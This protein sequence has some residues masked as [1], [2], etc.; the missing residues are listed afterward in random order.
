MGKY[1]WNIEKA[2][3]FYKQ[4]GLKLITTT[5]INNVTPMLAKNKDGYIGYAALNMVQAN[6]DFR[7]FKPSYRKEILRYNVD[8]AMKIYGIKD[9]DIEDIY[10]KNNRVWV[11]YKCTCRNIYD[12]M[13][14]KFLGKPMCPKCSYNNANKSSESKI[15]SKFLEKGYKILKY[16][17]KNSITP[18]LV[19]DKDGYI[20]YMAYCNILAGLGFK[21][22]R[23][24]NVPI[25]VI[26]HNVENYFRINNIDYIDIVKIKRDKGRLYIKTKCNNCNRLFWRRMDDIQ[27][28]PYKQYCKSC[29]P[30]RSLLEIQVRDYLEF[31]NINFLEEYVFEGKYRFDFYLPEYNL[32]IET[33]DPYHFNKN[34]KRVQFNDKQKDNICKE[35]NIVLL[36]LPYWDFPKQYKKIIKNTLNKLS[37]N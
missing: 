8:N 2:K 7:Y 20:G 9:V 13:I 16:D 19:E 36:R 5:Y 37:Y 14:W 18:M 24:N 33:D 11:K 22:L 3:E 27:I 21:P 17:Y 1:K 15:R 25:W 28:A 26:R 35:R 30:K 32:C 10:I 4:H 31:L 23:S 34:N 6:K 29:R 12:K